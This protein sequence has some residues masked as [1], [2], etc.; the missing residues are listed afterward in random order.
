[1]SLYIDPNNQR[2]LWETLHK[3]PWISILFPNDRISQKKKELWFKNIISEM[4]SQMPKQ[5][6]REMLLSKNKETLTKMNSEL[7]QIKMQIQSQGQ[8]QAQS[9]VQVQNPKYPEQPTSQ[10][11]SRNAISENRSESL[12]RDYLDRQKQYEQMV[13]KPNLPEISFEE[14][15]EDEVIKNMDE[16]IR[17]QLKEREDDIKTITKTF[18]QNPG[19]ISISKNPT[20]SIREEVVDIDPIVV[21]E[22]AKKRVSW[23]IDNDNENKSVKTQLSQKILAKFE[24]KIDELIQ[25]VSMLMDFLETKFPNFQQEYELFFTKKIVREILEEEMEKIIE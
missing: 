23:S 15:K 16:L 10:I 22:P 20:L 17:K 25:K 21:E 7:Y 14:K 3:N 18:Q 12:N 11:Y 9:Q 24:I 1:M 13:Q 8:T 5:I 4:Y 6:S 19:A 2:I